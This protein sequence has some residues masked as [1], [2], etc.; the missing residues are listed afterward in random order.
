MAAR[1]SSLRRVL[2]LSIVGAS[3]GAVLITALVTVGLTRIGAG[4]RA[5]NALRNEASSIADVASGLPCTDATRPARLAR[6]LGA[7]VRFVPDG[8]RRLLASVTEA[9]GRT[10]LVGRDVYFSSAPAT[11]CGTSGRLFVFT[12]VRDAPALPAGF[13]R[14]LLLAGVIAL[15]GAALLA[16]VLSRRMSRP[17]KELAD[18]A[19]AFN[20]PAS[21]TASDTVEVAELKESLAGM[22]TDLRDSRDREKAFLLSISHE[23]RTP[24]T[25]I[26]GYAEALADGTARRPRQAGEVMLGESQRLERLVQD[27]LDL[28]RIEAG[29]FSIEPRRV[30]L[31]DIAASVVE[32]L[33]PLAK[34]QDVTLVL[35]APSASIVRTDADRVHQMIANLVENAMRVTPAKKSVRVEVAPACLRV[36]DEGPGLDAQDVAHA[37]E[38]FYLWRR[39]RGDRQVGTGLGLAIVGELARRLGVKV[40]IKSEPDEGT[41]FEIRFDAA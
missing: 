31:C 13:G 12:A 26:R 23:L 6:Q 5:I 3:L 36:R 1:R 4:Q 38:R 19:R 10:T 2:L 17:L 40:D 33:R 28:G 7:R 20:V 21:P 11:I 15:L 35:D 32:A 39:Y 41:I 16:F 9:E 8:S 22:V 34:E 14:R 27:L 29:E 18:S 37:F 24:L 30:D 25:A